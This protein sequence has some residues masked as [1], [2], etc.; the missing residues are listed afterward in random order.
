M[1]SDLMSSDATNR[2]AAAFDGLRSKMVLPAR[3]FD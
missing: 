3:K 1:S 2:H